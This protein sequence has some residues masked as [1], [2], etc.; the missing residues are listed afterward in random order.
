[1]KLF[2]LD[3]W[4]E[5][6]ATMRANKLRTALTAWGVFWGIFMLV[7]ALGFGDGLRRGVNAKM[8][9]TAA[10]AIFVWGQRTTLPSN[11]FKPGRRIQFVVEDLEAVRRLPNLGHLA[12]RL[13][14][15]GFRQGVPVSRG[16]ET[17]AYEV[18]GDF[19]AVQHIQKIDITG[20]FINPLDLDESRKVA[21]I[22][23]QVA[24]TLFERGEDPI[25]KLIKIRGVAFEVI[26]VVD[27]RSDGDRRDRDEQTI[28]IPFTSFQQAFNTGNRIN[29]FAI[30]AKDNVPAEQFEEEFKAALMARHKVHP[31][32]LRALG[33]WNMGDEFSKVGRLFSAINL[34]LWLV[35]IATLLAGALGVSNILL[36]AVKERTKEIGI[37][38]A[39]GARPRQIVSLI[40]AESI[41]LT[42]VAGY[43]GLV[44]AVGL[45]EFFG[46]LTQGADIPIADPQVDIK[47]ALIATGVLIVSGAIAGI[48]PAMHAAR[49]SPIESLRAE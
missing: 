42:S 40:L 49:V 16:A 48:I 44:L 41:T 30:T 33:S 35:G 11:G 29:F 25:G 37:R 34:L 17:G 19:P 2:D 43:F 36:I 26:G 38:K 32:D 27:P 10:N 7:V 9:G 45:L 18:Y 4:A 8:E 14:L 6:F 24:T 22:G 3:S 28:Y 31:N 1:M 39:L 5:V 12:P 46:K 13:R 21:V 20:R 47:V 15:G 23:R